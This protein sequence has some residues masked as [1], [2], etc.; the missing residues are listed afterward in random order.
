M[1]EIGLIYTSTALSTCTHLTMLTLGFCVAC[2]C[3]IHVLVHSDS[4]FRPWYRRPSGI[5]D[6][7]SSE[8]EGVELRTKIIPQFGVECEKV[9]PEVV[10]MI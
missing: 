7:D 4:H 9:S 3:S 8:A 1:F 5:P 6:L 10:G 2:L